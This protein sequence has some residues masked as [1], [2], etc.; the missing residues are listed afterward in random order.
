MLAQVT[1]TPTE[2]KKLIAKAISRMDIV[3]KAVD[4]GIV[5]L[6]PSSS[7]YFLVEEITGS[8]PETEVWVCG[9]IVPRGACVEIGT[10]KL[11]NA[12]T[13]ERVEENASVIP[14]VFKHTW[15][16]RNI[17]FTQGC[18]LVRYSKKW[19]RTTSILRG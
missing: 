11:P 3:R 7:A 6:H 2:S 10:S 8:K 5:V 13:S 15:V 9:V 19:G 12:A 14:E 1:L 18:H 16:I 17:N 4:N